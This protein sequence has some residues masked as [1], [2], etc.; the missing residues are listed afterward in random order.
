MNLSKP[1]FWILLL[2]TQ[3]VFVNG[4]E[5][6]KLDY[7]TDSIQIIQANLIGNHP[8]G[9]YMMRLESDFRIQPLNKKHFSI[10]ISSAN[11]W[12]PLVTAYKPLQQSDKDLMNNLIWYDREYAFDPNLIPNERIQLHADAIIKGMQMSFYLPIDKQQELRFDFRSYLF[13]KGKIPFSLLSSDQFL[14]FFH[15]HIAG[16]EDPFARKYYGLDQVALTYID[17]QGR[18]IEKKENDFV[19]AGLEAH[20]TY[21]IPSKFLAAQDF[22][23]HLGAHLGMNTTAYNP[24]TDFG[25]SA[26]F[27][28]QI[29]LSESK[30]LQLASGGSLSVPALIKWKNGVNISNTKLKFTADWQLTYQVKT[31]KNNRWEIALNYHHLSAYQRKK[32]LDG[33]VLIGERISTHWHYAISHLYDNTTQW[34]L[35]FNYATAKYAISVYATEDIKVNNAPDIQTGIQL[36]LPL[37]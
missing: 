24:T 25:L 31:A 28:K 23:I 21:F 32:D 20:Y 11:V 16:G 19:F 29:K 5:S 22:Y 27:I 6:E 1:V 18:S 4:Q 12:E 15:S 9:M 26:A 3:S 13:T 30:I 2:V 33:I 17:E 14:E 10:Q 7:S 36:S 8:L 37:K 35:V 34:T